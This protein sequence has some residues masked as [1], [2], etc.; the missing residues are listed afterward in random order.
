MV[1]QNPAL[2]EHQLRDLNDE[3]N[4]L[5]REKGH[6]EKRIK[7]LGGPDYAKTGPKLTDAEGTLL[8]G[9]TGRG[10]GYRYFGAAKNL[11]GVKE[12]FDKEPARQVRKTRAQLLAGIDA[13]YYGFRDEDD[14]ILTVVEAEAEEK[15]RAA[16][17]QE[18]EEKEQL[19]LE[20]L[21]QA[22]KKRKAEM[23]NAEGSTGVGSVALDRFMAYVPLPDDKEIEA[24][25]L[26]KK[27]KD[28]LSKYM[29]EDLM[30]NQEKTSS[31]LTSKK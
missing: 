18:W 22:N 8:D 13:D 31:M 4:K 28:L 14:G 10:A 20:D 3:I 24:R 19:R 1:I 2:G 6:W 5:L 15:M 29:S 17:I 23:V 21:R 12:L 7:E 26:E 16:T 30:R 27:K 9:A 25:V 11:P